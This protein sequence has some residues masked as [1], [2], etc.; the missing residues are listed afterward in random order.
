[1]AN[2][3]ASRKYLLTINNPEEHGF[4]HE[5]IKETLHTF[6]GLV[7]WCMCNEIGEQGTPHLHL[8]VVFRNAVKMSTIMQRFYGAH[9]DAANGSHSENR[10]YVR[11]EGK[12]LTDSKHETSKPNTFEESGQLPPERGDGKRMMENV[13]EMIKTGASTAEI[14]DTYPQAISK[15]D[16]IEKARQ[17]HLREQNKNV[18]RDV[19]CHYIFGGTGV[20]KTR[21]VMEKYGYSNVYRVTDYSHPFDN[22]QGQDVILFDEFHDSIEI[23]QMLTLLDGYPVDLPCRYANKSAL[24]TK[25]YVISNV[26]FEMQYL[27]V[28]RTIP[29]KWKAFQR[30]FGN[31]IY[32]MLQ[33]DDDES[34]F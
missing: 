5:R 34:P 6:P 23:T 31:Q 11:K 32:E 13:Y 2:S 16:Y 10:D 21:S 4:S 8:Y 15:I 7:Y 30:R 22:Y 29:E 27:D 28:Q 14:I 1:M 18:W 9:I 17:T 12:W 33:D 24:Y 25:V 26:P 20:G 19:D 3:F